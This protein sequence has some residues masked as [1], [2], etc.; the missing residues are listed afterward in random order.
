MRKLSA[1]LKASRLPSQS[2]IFFPLLLGQA[3]AYSKIGSFSWRLFILIHL[4]GLLIQLYIVY[5]NDYADKD[6]D[7]SNDTYNLFSGGSRVLVE[8]EIKDKDMKLAI[9]IMIGLN[10]LLGAI[11][12]IRFKRLLAL[13]LIIFSLLLLWAYSYPPLKIS[14]RGGGEFLQMTGVAGV[15]PVFAYY[16]QAGSLATFPCLILLILLP[17]HLACAIST[18]L[19]DRP[20]DKENNKRTIPVIFNLNLAK[21][22]I[23]L[24]NFL[25][26]VLLLFIDLVAFEFSSFI[27]IIVTMT[28]LSLLYYSKN[29]PPGSK[30]LFKFIAINILSLNIFMIALSAYFFSG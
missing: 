19:P 25:S 27:L 29:S 24:L 26:A 17:N 5:A 14:Y 11:L 6:I 20:S 7:E 28:N 1:W 15:L 21:Y 30:R 2:Y 22:S 12:T 4:F 13:P 9:Q 18:A 23:I 8:G 16:I 10:L 3:L